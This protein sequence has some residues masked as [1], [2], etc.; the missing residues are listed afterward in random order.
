MNPAHRYIQYW[1]W[2]GLVLIALMVIIG[3]ITRLTGS[4]LSMVEWKPVT[5]VVPP[6]DEGDW[7]VEFEKYKMFPEYQKLNYNMTVQEFKRIYFWEY[8][9]RLLGRVMGIIFIVPLIIF[10]VRKWI[11][12]KLLVSLVVI[13][14]LGMLQGVMGWYM[15]KSGLSSVP[16]VSHFRLAAHQALALLLIAALLWTSLSLTKERIKPVVDFIFVSS[17]ISL[18]LLI[19]QMLLGALVAGLKAGYSYTNFP[20]MGDTFFPSATVVNAAPLL[21]NGVVLQFIHRWLGFALFGSILLSWFQAG[22]G[23]WSCRILSRILLLTALQIILGILT[24]WVHVPVWLGV[25]HQFIA[26]LLFASII[27]FLHK[28]LYT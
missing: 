8:L 25:V 9:H 22:R 17:A 28:Q 10:I 18:I 5:G 26:I 27:I 3:G 24:L 16:H 21:Y 23:T 7:M 1:L 2:T 19:G 13:F 11:G 20:L 4:G 14:V 6:L 15:V 12:R